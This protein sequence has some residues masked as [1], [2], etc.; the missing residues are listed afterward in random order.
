MNIKVITDGMKNILL[1]CHERELLGQDPMNPQDLKL[2][3]VFIHA[4]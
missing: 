4:V 3:K 2:L 1:E